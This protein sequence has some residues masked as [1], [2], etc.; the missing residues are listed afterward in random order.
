MA[1]PSKSV[2]STAV[3]WKELSDSMT[4]TFAN[5]FA[6]LRSHHSIYFEQVLERPGILPKYDF[7]ALKK[8]LPD[9]V[10]TLNSLEKQYETLSIPYGKIPEKHI[11]EIDKWKEYVD[12]VITLHELKTADGAVE[13]KKI[14]DKWARAPPLE[15]FARDHYVEYFPKHFVDYRIEE[16][17][18]DLYK[19]GLNENK[20][21]WIWRF[22]DYKVLRHPEK[23]DPH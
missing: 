22:K 19:I 14:E 21:T 13:A 12:L 7:A 15:H 1:R 18:F 3:K 5:Y 17:I 20:D 8:R 11:K 16:R 10:A 23:Q 6:A 2:V 9:H 4:G